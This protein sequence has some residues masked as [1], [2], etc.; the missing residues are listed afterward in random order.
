MSPTIWPNEPPEELADVTA[1]RLPDRYGYRMQDIFLRELAP[2]LVEGVRILD[3]GAGRSPT[4]PPENRPPGTTYV[5]L[6]ISDEELRSA[7]P[8]AY[9]ETVIADISRPN[10]ELANFDLIISWQVLE[11]VPSLESALRN[12]GAML[13]PGGVLLAQTSGSYAAFAMLARIVPHRVRVWAMARMLGHA[14]EQ[15]FPIRYDR[16]TAGAITSMLDEWAEVRI[17]SF[18]RAAP[19]F[20]MSAPLQRIYLRYENAIARRDSVTLATH[21]LIVARR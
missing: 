2:L 11:H 20:G 1:G 19:Y 18:Y 16:C 14:E 9:D 13:K 10:A 5:G 3:V 4:I 8:G 6:D 21:Y 15:K 12:L 17:V 7:P